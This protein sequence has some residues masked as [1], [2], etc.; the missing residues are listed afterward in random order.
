MNYVNFYDIIY[1]IKKI[2]GFF[3]AIKVLTSITSFPCPRR[4]YFVIGTHNGIFH[5]DDVVATAILCLLHR[6]KYIVVVRSRD[7]EVL[8]ECDILVNIGGGE[9][10]H[11][12]PGFNLKR[13][14]GIPYA[15]AGLVWKHFGNEIILNFL[16]KANLLDML[17]ETSSNIARTIDE[18][19]IQFVDAENNG[20]DLGLHC[21]SFISTYLPEWYESNPNFEKL[22]HI[23]I[24]VLE[25][26]IRQKIAQAYATEVVRNRV[27]TTQYFS[28]RIL[29]IPSQTTP[30]L[31]PV[32][33]INHQKDM[34]I[35]FVIFPYPAGGWAAQCVPLS[36]KEPFKQ[37]VPF[38]KI[39]AGQTERLSDISGVDDATFCHNNCFF[40]RAKSKVGVIRMCEL[41]ME[42]I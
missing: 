16:E 36:L 18:N 34:D 8:N 40:V 29:E 24:S 9:F 14:N 23:V 12:I 22:L 28:N 30:W 2:G 39:W 26:N 1:A 20:I 11:H 33:N 37:L 38:P 13:N 5:S 41:A 31:E 42:S 17:S 4:F 10:D 21:F 25:Q 32:C 15:S 35:A 27:T 6:N 3:M 19:V 7:T